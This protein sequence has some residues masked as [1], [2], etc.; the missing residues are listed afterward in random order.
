MSKER[1]LGVNIQWPISQ[2]IISGE[3]TVETRTYPIPEKY[4]NKE[5]ALVETP[6]RLGKFKA[7]V[8]AIIK[9]TK[10]FQYKDKEDFYMD[11][12]RH[13]VSPES[14]WAWKEKPKWGWEVEVTRVL[15]N[16]IL[17]KSKGIVYR[18]GITI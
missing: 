1:Y 6:G 3:K 4:L 12:D 7:R 5:I 17:C 15:E 13:K 18:S 9:F 11:I 14:N 16:P 8:I 10:S 2:L